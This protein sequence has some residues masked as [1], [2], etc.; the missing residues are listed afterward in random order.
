MAHQVI[1]GRSGIVNG[2]TGIREW[3]I[4]YDGSPP[5]YASSAT[6]PGHGSASGNTDWSG[7]Y[8]MYGG[9][10]ANLPG[11]GFTFQGSIDGSLGAEG[12]AIVDQIEIT[13]N[14][15]EAVIISSV[16]SFSAN[17]ALVFGNYAPTDATVP[18]FPS[19]IGTE[20]ELGIAAA[21]PTLIQVKDLR[22]MTL[23]LTSDNKSYVSSDTGGVTKR[24][25]GQMNFTMSFSMYEGDWSE[26]EVLNTVQEMWLYVNSTEYWKLKWVKIVSVSD[27]SVGIESADIVSATIS[28]QMDGF[29]DIGGTPTKG[30][31]IP[32]GGGTPWW[33]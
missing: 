2:E 14:I 21:S 33:P 13:W 31:V 30:T 9:F 3:S 27:L 4:S 28:G 22:S 7:S 23:T 26:L 16:V 24:V 11:D 18:D 5:Q 8:N 32:P 29:T 17:G 12:V 19:S 1:S 10:P 20:L 6:G 15:E 25:A